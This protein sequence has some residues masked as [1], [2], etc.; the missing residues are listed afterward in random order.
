EDPREVWRGDRAELSALLPGR[1]EV[2][3]PFTV[4][5]AL[6][7]PADSTVPA[8]LCAALAA[9]GLPARPAG[10]PFGTDASKLARAGVPAV[11]FGPGA[12]AEAHSAGE[13]IALADVA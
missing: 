6:D 13:S 4:D 9:A 11:V 5:D 10:M 7:T 12:L 8:A 3:E 1:I 2:D